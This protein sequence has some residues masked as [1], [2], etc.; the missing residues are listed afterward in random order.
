MKNSYDVIV[1]GG[2]HA[3]VEAAHAVARLG[4]TASLITLSI[5]KIANMPCNP[6]I[7]G[8][9][10]GVVVR[11]VDALGGIMGIASDAHPLQIKMLNTG[12]GPGVQC[13]RSQQDKNLYPAKILSLL[14]ENPNIDILEDEVLSLVGEGGHIDGVQT[15][16][17]GFLQSKA[18]ILCA[19]TYLKAR[20]FT[21]SEGKDEGPD[22]EP[23][24]LTLSDELHRLGVET[25]R[26][27]TGTPPRLLKSSIDFSKA[28][29]EP[30]MDGELA[31]SYSTTEFTPLSKQQPC[32]L[33]YTTDKTLEIIRENLDSSALFNGTISSVGPRYCPSI[34][35]K[36]VR[37]ADKPRHQLFLEP[38]YEDGESIYL[39]GF[40]TAMPKEVQE[41]MVHSLPGLEHA[42]LL[43]YAYQIEYD[44]VRPEE[45]DSC[46]RLKKTDNLYIAGQVCGTSGYEEAAGLGLI[47]GAN[48]ALKLLGKNPLILKRNESYIGVMIDDLVT[49]GTD[50]PYRLLSSRAE[51]RLLLRHDN[52]DERLCPIAH[53]VGL[54]PESAYSRYLDKQERVAM[55]LEYLKSNLVEDR[56]G[57][58]KV[59]EEKGLSYDARGYKGLELLKRPEFHYKDLL[60]LMPALAEFRL[61]EDAILSL[62]TK[63]KFEG[64]LVKQKKDAENLLKQEKLRLPEELDYLHMDGLR[65][66]ARQKLAAV[67]PLSIGQAS[68]ISGVN[69]ADVSVLLL[70][71]KKMGIL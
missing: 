9:A 39:Q 44:A 30:G 45:F 67:R 36:V 35:S 37:F 57:L 8:S 59:F 3:G 13:L 32:Y 65:L 66:E 64:Y 33:I 19:G 16:K 46:L 40:S 2:G 22:G 15:K 53:E 50:E 70:N 29:I 48:A 28:A 61:N 11:E 14:R 47:A 60:P 71:L 18:V 42:V 21:G 54:L 49:K 52:A 17:N 34:E 31:F 38:E 1:I 63:V 12:K 27:K 24:S 41:E 55:A 58:K 10:K 4:L 23:A 6:H 7:G 62:E 56:D 20:V 69:P 43:K 5:D 68:R 26:L 25:W 51:Y